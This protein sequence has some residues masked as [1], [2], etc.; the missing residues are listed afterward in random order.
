MHHAAAEDL[1]PAGVLAHR[2][3]DPAAADAA[4][5]DFGAGLR[6]REEA[7]TEAHR[8]AG[9]E[10]RLGHRQQRALQVRQRDAVA[11]HQALALVEHRR[12]GEIEVVAAVDRADGDQPHRGLVPL[13]VADLH[14]RGVRTQ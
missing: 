3:A 4:D 7:G 6:V 11:D 10:E 2:A 5:V 9:A 1:E 14:R 13:H 12:V 8:R